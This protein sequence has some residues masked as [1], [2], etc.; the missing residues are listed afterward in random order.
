MTT[1]V[2]NAYSDLVEKLEEI[3]RLGGVMST[4]HWDQEV[5]MPSGAAE[6]RAK[7]ISALAGV[8]HERSTDPQLGDCLSALRTADPAEFNAF[9]A[10][11]IREAQREYDK[12]TKVPK[13]L[14]QEMAELGS[15]GHFVWIKAREDNKFCDFAPTLKRFIELKKEWAAHVFT[16]LAPYDANIDNFERGTTMAQIAPIFERLKSE[17]IPL[18][19]TVKEAKYQPDTSFLEG[20]FPVDRQEALGKQISTDMGFAF[21]QGRMDVSVHPFCGG[22]HPTDVRI[23]TRYRASDFV[24][25]LYAVIHETGHGLY[26]QGRMQEGRDLPVSEALTMGIHE[27]QSLFWERMIAQNKAFCAHY[28]ET[29]RAAF[30]KNL[31]AVSVDALYEA[32]NTCEPSFIRVEADEL[33]YPLH[34]ILRF[35]I[36]RGLFDGSVSVDQLPQLW[37]EKMNDYLGVRPPTDTLG[38][39]QD[40]HWSGGA[41]GYFPSYTLGAMYACQFFN[42]MRGEMP[43]TVK[44]IE[45]G[46]FA[47]IKSWLNDKIHSQG[48]LYRPRELV[49]RITGEPLNPDHFIDYLKAKY[50]AIYQII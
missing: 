16:D 48:S 6:S 18:I 17:L 46:N 22:G 31:Q 42:T 40:V 26:E 47:P 2:K 45:A 24:E 37:N 14:V 15:R 10:C 20:T 29:I 44:Y 21:D 33:T 27:S 35:E 25:S 9:E 3:S 8:I 41:F 7:Q 38:V 34:V 12:E 5:I 23:T 19:Q 49:Q 36:E 39:L 28:I 1:N 13:K 4:L 11:N 32:I 50:R 30:P 43:D